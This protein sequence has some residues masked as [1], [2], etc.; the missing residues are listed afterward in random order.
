MIKLKFVATMNADGMI[1]YYEPLYEWLKEENARNGVTSGQ[2]SKWARFFKFQFNLAMNR[3]K[4]W[5]EP[6]SGWDS[7]KTEFYPF[8]ENMDFVGKCAENTKQ[9]K[10]ETLFN[11]DQ[12]RSPLRP[13]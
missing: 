3:I 4:N 12:I 5:F 6:S 9:E 7:T 8:D 10:F 2:G 13:E 11:F 1:A